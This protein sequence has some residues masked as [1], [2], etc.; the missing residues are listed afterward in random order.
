MQTAADITS[1]LFGRTSHGIKFGLERMVAAAAELGNPQNAYQ[2]IH[3]AGT[4]GKGS[5]SAFIDSV[6]RENGFKTGLF[7]SPHIIN[8]E[9]RFII[10]GRP[11]TTPQWMEVYR[12]LAPIIEKRGLTF[13][14]S[15]T[16]IGF[17]LFKREKVD[18][19]VFETGMG[20]RLDSTNIIAPEA[21]SITTIAMDH[22]SYLGNDLITIAGEK[23]GI[24]KRGVPLVMALPPQQE[25]AECAKAKC[26]DMGS[27]LEFVSLRDAVDIR[28]LETGTEFSFNGRRY[29]TQLP[30]DYQVQ[31]CLVALKTLEAAGLTDLD[32]SVRGI[33]KTFLPGRFQVTCVQNRTVIFDV[34][35]NPNAAEQ[36]VKT[37]ETR[38][39]GQSICIVTGIMKDKDIT[40]ILATYCKCAA[41]LVLTQPSIDRAADAAFLAQNVPSDYTRPVEV[42]PNVKDAV[43][44][45]LKNSEDVICITGSFY[46]VGEAMIALGVRPFGD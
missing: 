15:I 38:F 29:F 3:I 28:L 23:L 33:E 41:R 31:N 5:T 26:K 14:E 35:H 4:N 8:F 10:D 20:G 16:L 42:V 34:G 18:W 7:T 43:F 44:A 12:G 36:L 39:T 19:A 45:A 25:I 22:M 40:S 6:L 32:I 13:F 9:E 37:L 11:I 17:E 24:V 30:G 46:T 27:P 21:A 2:S 1:A